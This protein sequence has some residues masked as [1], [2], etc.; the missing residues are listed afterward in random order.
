MFEVPG[1]GE[2]R[3]TSLRDEGEMSEIECKERSG[4]KAKRSERKRK[5]GNLLDLRRSVVVEGWE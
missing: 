4:V 5:S 1:V 2:E 3:S